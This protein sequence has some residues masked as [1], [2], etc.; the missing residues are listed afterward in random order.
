MEL[1]NCKPFTFLAIAPFSAFV[2]KTGCRCWVIKATRTSLQTQ[3]TSTSFAD[4]LSTAS[5]SNKVVRTEQ[6]LLGE[7]CMVLET[8]ITSTHLGTHTL[9]GWY[10]VL[11]VKLCLN[12][13]MLAW[14]FLGLLIGCSGL[15][16][17][18]YVL[19]ECSLLSPWS[20]FEVAFWFS[21][22]PCQHWRLRDGHQY[23][24]FNNFGRLQT[25]H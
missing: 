1:L 16:D 21:R 3:T 2:V 24:L 8:Q 18:Q 9:G 20:P 13:L 7:S 23:N 17:A 5:R 11:I 12:D 25:Y 10:S 6:Q 14:D 19:S 4:F 15:E 22:E